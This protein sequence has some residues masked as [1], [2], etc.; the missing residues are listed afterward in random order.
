MTL[1]DYLAD[2]AFAAI[3]DDVPAWLLPATIV[4]RAALLAAGHPAD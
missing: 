4:N 1:H 3:E 2:A